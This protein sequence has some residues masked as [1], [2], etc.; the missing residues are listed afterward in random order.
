MPSPEVRR[1]H[2]LFYLASAVFA[3]FGLAGAWLIMVG[4]PGETSDFATFVRFLAS[5]WMLL[6]F[7]VAGGLMAY[8]FW[9]L[10]TSTSR[11]SRAEDADAAMRRQT[12]PLALAF[13]AVA[14]ALTGIGYLFVGD[15]DRTFREERFS[16]QAAIARLKAQ[17]VDEWLFKG[18]IQTE[19]LG[20]ALQS[21]PLERLPADPDVKQLVGLVC[22]EFLA[23][24]PEGVAVSLFGGD[25]RLLYFVGEGN[26]PDRETTKAALDAA[27]APGRLRIIDLHFDQEKPPQA[28]MGFVASVPPSVGSKTAA[29]AVTVDPSRR[30]FAQVQAWPTPSETSEVML[31]GRRGDD[32]VFLTP[33]QRITPTPPPLSFRLPLSR[34]GLPAAEAVLRGDGV[35][36][37]TDYRDVQVLTASH[38]VTGLP[39][40][41]VAKTDV[42]EAMRPLRRQVR[43]I[44]LVISATV[45]L[46]G[47]MMA[48]LWRAQRET[49]VNFRDRQLEEHKA[50]LQ[51]FA[52][53]V[54]L[55]RDIVLLTGPEGNVVDA[56]EAAMAAYGYS[57]DEFRTLNIRDIQAGEPPAG[58]NRRLAGAVHRRKDGTTFPVEITGR[59][60]DINGK[61]YRQSFVR[62]VSA[63]KAQEKA[64]VRLSR[65][66]QAVQAATSVLLRA[67]TETEIYG[68][69][70]TIMIE[71]GDYRL[72]CVAVP[73]DGVGPLRVLAGAGIDEGYVDTVLI[74]RGD[75]PGAESPA[76]RALRT[77]ETQVDQ[78]VA[79]SPEIAPWRDEALKRDLY[80]CIGLP[81]KV[82]GKTF[83]V[84][85]FYA[86][87]PDAFG[88]DEISLLDD[89]ASDISFRVSALRAANT[90]VAG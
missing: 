32:V 69:I 82:Q 70:C 74:A 15:I 9:Y 40:F 75:S 61:R 68:Q 79:T 62:D 81:L 88:I 36:K 25:G 12:V 85:T 54:Q 20:K 29:V 17:Q 2:R 45:V 4:L 48:A 5:R 30:F 8:A 11:A 39:W 73:N 7:A 44:V 26:A 27:A 53:L 71:L 31:V 3:G 43:A 47:F 77:G 66:T 46:A 67:A 89:L 35:R 13:S 49:F 51:H 76:N 50:L 37:G 34:T 24:N 59:A 19:L 21:L 38:H 6:T 56:N 64:L 55:S 90:V 72:A 58:V 18:G 42:E 10:R 86:A 23:R 33:P 1:N 80:A 22:A 57:R 14:L 83:G 16:Q 52:Q 41:V 87:E 78:N 28:R 84:L 65:V 63:R 60:V